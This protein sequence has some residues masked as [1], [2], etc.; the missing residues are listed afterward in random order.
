MDF[1][2]FLLL[3]AVLYIRPMDFVP[4]VEGIYSVAFGICFVCSLPALPSPGGSVR[5]WCIRSASA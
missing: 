2:T 1:A 5:P 4:G 3:N